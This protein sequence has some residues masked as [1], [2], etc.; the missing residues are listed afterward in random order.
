MT[1]WRL[2]SQPAELASKSVSASNHAKIVKW[3]FIL[4]MTEVP[5]YKVKEG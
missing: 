3:A 2:L 4:E 1:L 5:V